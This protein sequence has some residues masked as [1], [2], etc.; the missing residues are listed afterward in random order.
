MLQKVPESLKRTTCL[1]WTRSA[2]FNM[3]IRATVSLPSGTGK[4]FLPTYKAV[5]ADC[6][7]TLSPSTTTGGARVK[8][9]APNKA[10]CFANSG[11]SET[12]QRGPALS[13]RATNQVFTRSIQSIYALIDTHRL[14]RNTG[15]TQHQVHCT[16][17]AVKAAPVVNFDL[18]C[19]ACGGQHGGFGRHV[20][21]GGEKIKKNL[22]REIIC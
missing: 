11:K 21:K 9:G 17:A 19:S 6:E 13:E 12:Y 8:V 22:M 7:M 16:S 18:F 15:S 5:A 3:C 2:M 4:Y 14:E 1:L 10:H 20:L